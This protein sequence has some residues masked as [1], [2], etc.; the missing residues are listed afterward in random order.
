MLFQ[1]A[2]REE[3][4]RTIPS[5]FLFRMSKTNIYASELTQKV[6]VWTFLVAHNTKE[7]S[8][9]HLR[10]F[11]KIPT[12]NKIGLTIELIGMRSPIVHVTILR[13]YF[14]KNINTK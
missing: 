4:F 6:L 7:K 11:L 9:T 14:S 1:E 8:K 13:G 12:L 3:S 2:K 5:L 10:N